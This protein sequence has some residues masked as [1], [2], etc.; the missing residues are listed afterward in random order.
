[1]AKLMMPSVYDALLSAGA[2][3]EKARSAAIDVANYD[4]RIVR[5]ESR[6]GAL[7]AKLDLLQW[8][9]GVNIAATLAIL[10]RMFF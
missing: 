3:D 5:V 9:V 1:M 8:M 7:A 4:D 6:L 2:D 10:I